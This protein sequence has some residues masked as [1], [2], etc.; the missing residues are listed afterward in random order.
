MIG[1]FTLSHLELPI[2]GV[3]EV[4]EV[5]RVERVQGDERVDGVEQARKG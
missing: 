1:E 4:G 2:E 3:E 5:E